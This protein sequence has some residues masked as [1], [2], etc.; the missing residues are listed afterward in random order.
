MKFK[1]HVLI[2]LIV[3]V[4][5]TYLFNLS[6][7][8]G[9]IIFLA[10]FLI[11]VDHYFWY[12]FETKDINPFHAIG[13]YLASISKWE[14]LSKKQSLNYKKGVFIFHNWICWIILLILGS[15]ID[16]FFIWILMGFIVHIIPDLITLK[17]SK[18]PLIQ[19]ISLSYVL[20][21]NKG[22]KSLTKL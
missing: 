9:T 20:K 4:I 10:S 15:I 14:K 13:W 3:S 8:T 19:K 11:D 2:G 1:Y 12:A 7:F 6:L 17:R 5:L 16:L 18:E 22:K 21:N